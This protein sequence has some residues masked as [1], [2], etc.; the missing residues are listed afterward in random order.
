MLAGS[1]KVKPSM[2]EWANHP[3]FGPDFQN[4]LEKAAEEF[5]PLP[6]ESDV[7]KAAA[8]NTG[9][10]DNRGQKRANPNETVGT[11]KTKVP[12]VAAN[13][14][15]DMAEVGDANKLMEFELGSLKGGQCHC[16]IKLRHKIWLVNR[17]EKPV[18]LPVGYV[19][20]GFGVGGYKARQQGEETDPQKE[21]LFDVDA[22]KQV[23]LGGSFQSV[24]G[25]LQKKRVTE[26]GATVAYHQVQ[27]D[28]TPENP[29]KLKVTRN[30]N[31]VFIPK[32]KEED[33]EEGKSKL[34]NR[35]GCMIPASA[36]NSHCTEISWSVRWAAM[37]MMPIRPVV[38]ITKAIDLPAQKAL[39]L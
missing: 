39:L 4:W 36:W 26:P 1:G 8:G 24:E 11:E 6:S 9:N 30:V 14:L 10:A 38:V 28:A 23:L 25:L 20:C 34:Q 33:G 17:S 13:L 27:E 12:R 37:G 29:S 16:H 31:V 18:H 21:Y 22:E 32:G 2:Q 15:K 19:L 5:G 7:K 3:R 35:I